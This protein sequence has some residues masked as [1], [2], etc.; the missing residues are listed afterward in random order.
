MAYA[1]ASLIGH[2]IAICLCIAFI[3]GRFGPYADLPTPAPTLD[4]DAVG[5]LKREAVARGEH[6]VP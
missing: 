3:K 1:I 4:D 2:A 5:R 6:I